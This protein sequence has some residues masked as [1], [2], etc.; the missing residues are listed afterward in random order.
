MLLL[1]DPASCCISGAVT[2]LTK[3]SGHLGKVKSG[4]G[5]DSGWGSGCGFQLQ[6]QHRSLGARGRRYYAS[7]LHTGTVEGWTLQAGMMAER[8]LDFPRVCRP[9][10]GNLAKTH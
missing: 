5:D 3:G 2:A 7:R 4:S 1:A 9:H 6:Q 8:T 10:V